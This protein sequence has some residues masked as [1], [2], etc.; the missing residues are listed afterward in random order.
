[1][2]ASLMIDAYGAILAVVTWNHLAADFSGHP[3]EM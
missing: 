1:M 2:I 3:H